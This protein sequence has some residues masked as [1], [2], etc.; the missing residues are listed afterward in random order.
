MWLVVSFIAIVTPNGGLK[1]PP[2][3]DL[4]RGDSA[5]PTESSVMF[6]FAP[7]GDF[8]NHTY[9]A[10]EII[11]QEKLNYVA[12]EYSNKDEQTDAES[13][14]RKTMLLLTNSTTHAERAFRI[15]APRR[16]CGI[17]IICRTFAR[18]R[19]GTRQVAAAANSRRRLSTARRCFIGDPFNPEKMAAVRMSCGGKTAYMPPNANQPAAMSFNAAP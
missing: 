16:C 17:P 6:L 19:S 13:T 3:C 5:R 18:L 9:S 11:A 12:T 15:S 4:C 10:I 2:D 8:D 14:Q 7:N 1:R